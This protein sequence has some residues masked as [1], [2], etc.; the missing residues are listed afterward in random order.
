MKKIFCI[1]KW[2][3]GF[4]VIALVVLPSTKN[5]SNKQGVNWI[6]FEQAVQF[7]QS[8][9][10]KVL[11]DVYTDWC[12]WCKRMDKTTYEDPSVVNYIN[13]HFY[14][15]KLNAESSKQITYNGK[16]MTEQNLSGQVF[17]V[18]GY[19]C[20]VYLDEKLR[21]LSPV[22]G[23]QDV[24][25]FNKINRFFAENYYQKMSLDDFFRTVQ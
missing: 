16:Q 12:G 24:A 6:T 4:I 1:K 13:K 22:P 20:T 21:V 5:F 25:M 3:I 11:I 23:Y 8:K 14:A 15:V 10:K 18:S 9:P 7:S 2:N 17:G 19:P